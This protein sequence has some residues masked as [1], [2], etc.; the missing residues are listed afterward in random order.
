MKKL[1]Y[2]LIITI[3]SIVFVSCE[4]E[5]Y[6][7]YPI[8]EGPHD[9]KYTPDR[10]EMTVDGKKINSVKYILLNSKEI[11]TVHNYIDGYLSISRIYKTRIIIDGYPK[12]KVTIT[13][14]VI[15]TPNDFKG[16]IMINKKRYNIEGEFTGSIHFMDP[17][18]IKIITRLTSE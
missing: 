16:T 5:N 17:Q 4:E 13:D 8:G 14:D 3:L 10:I 7:L 6:I 1:A 15:S 2:L 9:D 11:D 18:K 12:G